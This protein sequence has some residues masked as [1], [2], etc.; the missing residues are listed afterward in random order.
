MKYL[1]YIVF[2]CANLYSQNNY[3]ISGNVKDKLTDKP[4]IGVNVFIEKLEVKTTTDINGD[5]ILNDLPKGK[6]IIRFS[7]VAYRRLVD[8]VK[9]DENDKKVNLNVA[10]RLLGSE[11]EVKPEIEKYH[12]RLDKLDKKE[13]LLRINIDSLYSYNG[14]VFVKSTFTNLSTDTL[15]II[16]ECPCFR[17]I[18]PWVYKDNLFV[19]SNSV[20]LDCDMLPYNLINMTD[21]IILLP[22][23]SIK[24]PSTELFLYNF[25]HLP[26]T[27]YKIGIE[28]NFGGPNSI[29]GIFNKPEDD[30]VLLALRGK[31]KSDNFVTFNNVYGK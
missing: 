11:I 22:N 21:L 9:V 18:R 1:L 14:R 8:T 10:L 2:I 15:F 23:E 16:K 31:Y 28:Y 19:K 6:H 3:T 29:H 17:I 4:L 5:Y 25:E 24:Y 20:S 7:Y 12:S 26:N 30:A 13:S 27:K